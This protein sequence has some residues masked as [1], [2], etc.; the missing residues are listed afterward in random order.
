[1]PG[2]TI[3]IFCLSTTRIPYLISGDYIKPEVICLIKLSMYNFSLLQGYPTW[4]L[5]T[6]LYLI[7]GHQIP[8]ELWRLYHTWALETRS[9]L[10]SEDWILPD[11]WRLYQT[12]YLETRCLAK[13]SRYSVSYYNDTLPDLWRLHQT[14]SLETRSLISGDYIIPEL[15]RL[16]AWQ[17]CPDILSLHFEGACYSLIKK[18][19]IIRN[20]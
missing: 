17:N 10:S 8:P 3:H 2:K 5:K 18:N 6:L 11:R 15:W 13:L 20:N 19:N 7:S 12:W 14:W 9:Y 1:M 16:D 4:S